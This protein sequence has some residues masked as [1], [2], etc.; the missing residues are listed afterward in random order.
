MFANTQTRRQRE[1]NLGGIHLQDRF[2][3][4]RDPGTSQAETGGCSRTLSAV[5]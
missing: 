2:E 1:T 5:R 3:G 4:G